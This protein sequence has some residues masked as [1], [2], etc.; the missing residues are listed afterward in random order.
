MYLK[1]S[2]TANTNIQ[3]VMR[4]VAAIIN[5]SSITSVA[6]LVSTYTTNSWHATVTQNFDSTNSE[7]IRTTSPTTSVAQIGRAHV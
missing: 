3:Q 4:M 7:I 2:F 5:T 1:L 6:S